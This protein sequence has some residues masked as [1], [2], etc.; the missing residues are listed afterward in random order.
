MYKRQLLTR[1]GYIIPSYYFTSISYLENLIYTRATYLLSMS[2]I[3]QSILTSYFGASISYIYPFL[4]LNILSVLPSYISNMIYVTASPYYI[5]LPYYTPTGTYYYYYIPGYYYYLP[6]S[7]PTEL[8]VLYSY[9]YNFIYPISMVA[10]SYI[11]NYVNVYLFTPYVFESSVITLMYN[12]LY[13]TTYEYPYIKTVDSINITAFE[14]P[15][16]IYT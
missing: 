3:Y 13:A 4:S 11:Q 8:A 2:Y 10:V 5:V 7:Y 1:Y 16:I 9:I 15:Y 14:M 6:P 12:T